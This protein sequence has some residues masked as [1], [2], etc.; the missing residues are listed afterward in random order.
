MIHVSI[1][2]LG[3]KVEE[4]EAKELLSPVDQLAAKRLQQR[5]KDL[6]E[7]FKCYHFTIIDLL[8]QRD[9]R[10]GAGSIQ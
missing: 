10:N 5:L 6:D 3:N 8:Q 7:D 2:R 1:T 4:L 9:D